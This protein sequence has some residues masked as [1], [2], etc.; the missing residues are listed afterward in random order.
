MTPRERRPDNEQGP[1]NWGIVPKKTPRPKSAAG[2][3]GGSG[4]LE[5]VR[6]GNN[7][8]SAAS[9]A[10][11]ASAASAPGSADGAAG[12]REAGSPAVMTEED[13]RSAAAQAI[14]S[15]T[16]DAVDA[17]IAIDLA[18]ATGDD[19]GWADSTLSAGSPASPVSLRAVRGYGRGPSAAASAPENGAE[20][21][22]RITA[23]DA[24]GKA[25]GGAADGAGNGA[26][27][28]AAADPA[29]E[30]AD[31]TVGE[32]AASAVDENPVPN[33][34]VGDGVDDP[35]E[36]DE[37]ALT[38]APVSPAGSSSVSTNSAGSA[39]STNSA[40]GAGAAQQERAAAG[41]NENRSPRPVVRPTAVDGPGNA[42]RS[43][44]TTT[45]VF[46][47]SQGRPTAVPSASSGAGSA[48]GA[49]APPPASAAP[50][51][52]APSSR[53]YGY[54]ARPAS[55]GS[56][57]A[58]GAAS[59]T[60]P[61]APAGAANTTNSST[62]SNAGNVTGS[63][64][65]AVE[66]EEDAGMLAESSAWEAATNALDTEEIKAQGGG[67]DWGVGRGPAKGRGPRR[68]SS[69]TDWGVGRGPAK[70]SGARTT[71]PWPAAVRRQRLVGVL[72]A[73]AGLVLATVS[74]M[75]LARNAEAGHLWIP[76]WL[77]AVLGG[78]GLVAAAGYLAWAGGTPLRREA[79]RWKPGVLDAAAGLTTGTVKVHD[80]ARLVAR[81]RGPL[82]LGT[83]ERGDETA[84]TVDSGPRPVMG[85][86]T[87]DQSTRAPAGVAGAV[88]GFMLASAVV[89]AVVAL[90]LGASWLI[91]T[92]A[93]T[94]GGI[95]AIRLAGEWLG[96][97]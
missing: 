22:R 46:T 45:R 5:V 24:V 69:G 83:S 34:D 64:A 17:A 68:P 11:G 93:L 88:G 14:A 19:T 50:A 70:S 35:E 13:M 30:T 56:G 3:P 51:P 61:G 59:R 52:G 31:E 58:P 33:G 94:L 4:L 71:S 76:P 16:A 38:G 26:A 43:G 23:V 97:V 1:V 90:I 60:A 47:I 95:V 2:R 72:F 77:V 48:S 42:P 36:R 32:A 20:A 87:V 28:D 21:E 25:A 57:D 67:T 89:C 78:A 62:A 65:S 53:G 39:N 37:P 63:T 73:L 75:N 84:P 29:G 85:T 18:D 91:A 10:S 41:V 74:A 55:S 6:P 54:Q 49:E 7:P 81:A 80:P 79:E 92:A 44:A 9:N 40:A 82:L 15:G 8:A 96:Q 12:A 66:P 27:R 86:S